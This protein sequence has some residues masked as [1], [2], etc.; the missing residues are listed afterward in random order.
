MSENSYGRFPD[1][2]DLQNSLNAYQAGRDVL[3]ADISAAVAADGRFV[4]VWLSG[5]FGRNEADAV[6]D[7]T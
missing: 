3:L 6:S 5:S 1:K 2:P 7:R 4:A